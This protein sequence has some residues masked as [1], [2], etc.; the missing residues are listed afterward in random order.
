MYVIDGIRSLHQLV[1]GYIL[2]TWSLGRLFLGLSGV[3][4]IILLFCNPQ[5]CGSDLQVENSSSF[6]SQ[7]VANCP[8]ISI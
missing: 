5:N 2:A 1:A 6:F 7:S 4:N 8:F 3:K